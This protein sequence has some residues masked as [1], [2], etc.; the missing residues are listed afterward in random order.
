MKLWAGKL[1]LGIL[2]CGRWRHVLHEH[3][4]YRPSP[5]IVTFVDASDEPLHG[6][7]HDIYRYPHYHLATDTPDRVDVDKLARIARSMASSGSPFAD[8]AAKQRVV[9][10]DPAVVAGL[11]AAV[12]EAFEARA[13]ILVVR[14]AFG[15][16]IAG[17]IGP[18][19]RPLAFASVEADESAV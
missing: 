15:T 5:A 18:I 13:R 9:V 2:L 4:R 6:Y 10:I 19:E 7:A 16:V 12:L 11:R 8:S 3:T 14:E 17:R 1:P